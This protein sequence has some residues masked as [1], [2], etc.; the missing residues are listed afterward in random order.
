[1]K[2]FRGAMREQGLLMPY[3][4]CDW[5]PEDHLARFIVEITDKLDFR[6]VYRQ[7]QEKGTI[8]P[9]IDNFKGIKI[10]LLTSTR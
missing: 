9:K 2:H 4:L 1:M 7:Y 3:D 6:N 10:S 5:L 8:K